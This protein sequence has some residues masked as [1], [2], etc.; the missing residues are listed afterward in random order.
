[1]QIIDNEKDKQHLIL[2]QGRIKQNNGGI[3]FL[4]K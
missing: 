4:W 3:D 1:M 2:E